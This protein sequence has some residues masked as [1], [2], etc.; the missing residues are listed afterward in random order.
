MSEGCFRYLKS[1]SS[2]QS[3]DPCPLW[4]RF[5]L[6]LVWWR[7]G[8]CSGFS[9]WAGTKLMYWRVDVRIWWPTCE[10]YRDAFCAL[11]CSVPGV[12]FNCL[13]GQVSGLVSHGQS[14]H[15]ITDP[16][17]EPWSLMGEVDAGLRCLGI[18]KICVTSRLSFNSYLFS[19]CGG[20]LWGTD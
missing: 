16:P 4:S 1:E 20:H 9:V 2:A 13:S 7:S 18:T 17:A 6:Y 8:L 19:C 14:G 10:G 11:M 15:T 12:V 3:L 5:V